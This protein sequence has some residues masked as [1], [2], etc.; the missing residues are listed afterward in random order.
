VPIVNEIFSPTADEI[1]WARD[2][3]ASA[4]RAVGEGRGAYAREGVMV[5][6]AIV[7]RA[8]AILE[9]HSGAGPAG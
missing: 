3:L 9:E 7:R 4:E 1:A 5:D 8:R 2:I 6:E